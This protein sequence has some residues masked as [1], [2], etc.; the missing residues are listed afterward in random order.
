MSALSPSHT[1][2]P[3]LAMAP[4]A[5]APARRRIGQTVREFLLVGGIT[6]FLYPISYL[7]R[8]VFGLDASELWVSFAFFYAAHLINDPHFGV[9]YV[10]F[11]RDWKR[12]AFGDAFT[13]LQRGR[14]LLAGFV[15][16]VVLAAWSLAA[17]AMKSAT[18][19]GH[20]FNLMYLLVG[21]HYVKQGFGVMA[22]L[23]ARR[24]VSFLPR[25]RWALL[26][27][28]FTGWAYAWASPFDPGR[29]MEEKGVVYM[30]IS[31]PP[32]LERI[33][34][35]LFLVSVIPVIVVLVQK[36]LREKKLPI[37]TPLLA[38]FCSVWPWTIYSSV[39][40]LVRYAI[41]ALHSIQYLYFVYLLGYGEAK[42]REGPPWFE[43]S[44]RSRLG[45]LAASALALGFLFFHGAPEVLDSALVAKKDRF[46]SLGP[47]PYFAA[48]YAFVNIHHYFM[49]H[50]IWRRE[51][52]LTRYLRH[53]PS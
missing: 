13:P 39:D 10:L 44:L 24:G 41:P 17:I 29:E 14:Y 47:T 36:R 23:S 1:A 12:R 21:W 26:A 15:V 38:L 2:V 32:W 45:L 19:M 27:H 35:V 42:E 46:S 50:V 31:Q 37:F 18:V 49:D 28:C 3:D 51:N 5:P 7:L 9:T 20:L 33:T 6:P 43:T 53:T 40:P 48:L 34:F 16:P 11:Y 4:I 52:P 22:V 30:S 8:R 25:E